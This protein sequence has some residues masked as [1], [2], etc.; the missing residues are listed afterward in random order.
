M[1]LQ[2][3][4]TKYDGK[5]VDWDKNYGPQCVDLYRQYVHEVLEIPQ[6]PAVPGAKDIWTTYLPQYFERI[7]NTP[8]GVPEPGDV[9]IWGTDL[10]Q[11]G[12]VSIFLSGGTTRFTSFD[13]NYPVGSL[14]HKQTHNYAGVLGWLRFKGDNLTELQECLALHKQ[15]VD[16]TVSLKK[17]IEGLKA[18]KEAMA[19]DVD[20]MRKAH[21]EE[22]ALLNVKLDSLL[23]LESKLQQEIDGRREDQLKWD[24]RRI[25]LEGEIEKLKQQIASEDLSLRDYKQLTEALIKKVLRYIE[26]LK[27]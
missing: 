21:A 10:G 23:S 18:E 12:H 5:A 19:V 26:S 20:N 6:S 14:C 11:Y 22:I 4:V 25:E 15:L 27:K 9:V 2:E 17:I 8:T 13:Q 7:T 3:F 1:T 24:M 16:E